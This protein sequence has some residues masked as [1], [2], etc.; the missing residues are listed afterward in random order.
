MVLYKASPCVS[1]LLLAVLVFLTNHNFGIRPVLSQVLPC[2]PP[3]MEDVMET[4]DDCDCFYAFARTDIL[5]YYN[6]Y[7]DESVFNYPRTGLYYGA[8]GVAEYSDWVF[9]SPFNSIPDPRETTFVPPTAFL[10]VKSTS[11]GQCELF[12]VTKTPFS[13][14]PKFTIDNQEACADVSVGMKTTFSLTGNRSGPKISIA[15][16]DVWTPELLMG[17]LYALF[18]STPRTARYVC[19][20]ILNTCKDYSI[21]DGSSRKL[22][23]SSSATSTSRSKRKL[24]ENGRKLSGIEEMRKCIR[25]FNALPEMTYSADGTVGY[26]D[27]DSKSCRVL[28][29]YMTTL[30][31]DHCPHVS[32]EREIDV[33]GKYKCSESAFVPPDSLFTEEEI[34]F[35]YSTGVNTFGYP[36]DSPGGVMTYEACPPVSY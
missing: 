20:K 25:R 1:T 35:I 5:D 12:L 4:Q 27:G 7:T 33:N 19:H 6:V 8:D 14:N 3:G 22:S 28:H 30:N 17:E 9:G 16:H 21:G 32:F 36:E 23:T 31:L 26:A 34:D 13:V 15:T 24:R 10:Y 11:P 29:S 18:Y 2:P